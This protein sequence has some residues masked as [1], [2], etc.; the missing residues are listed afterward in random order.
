MLPLLVC[1][2][3][4]LLAPRA[5]RDEFAEQL[6]R[7]ASPRA[8]ERAAAERWLEAHLALERYPELAE[9]ALA[10]DAEVRGRLTRVLSSDA[11]H[12]GL[13]L[14]LCAEKD[15]GLAAL[16]REAL[17]TGVARFDPSLGESPVRGTQLGFFLKQLARASP[18]R[19]LR[20]DANLS[21][22]EMVEVLE[23]SGEVPLGLTFDPRLATKT[24]RREAEPL[25]GPWEQVL[26]RL[27]NSMGVGIEGHGLQPARAED[28]HEGF[29]RL[30]P[31]S[32]GTRTGVELLVDWLLTLATSAEPGA[33]ARAACNLAS[34]GFAPALEWMD[35]LVRTRDDLAARQG[36]LRAALRGR[37]ARSLS[38][39][40]LLDSLLAESA[41]GGPRSAR[42]LCALSRVPCFDAEGAA[43]APHLLQD[44]ARAAPRARWARLVLLE[45]AGCAVPELAA[46]A[47]ALLADPLTPPRLRLQALHSLAG[48]AGPAVGAPSVAGLAELV[49][50]G[51]DGEELERLG[52]SLRTLG[53]EPPY[54]EPS[55]VPAAWSA[56]ARLDLCELWLWNG[57]AERIAAHLLGWLE[58]DARAEPARGEA[59]ADALRGW[60]LRGEGARVD[61]A[62]ARAAALRPQRAALLERVRLL[63]GRVPPA[64]VGEALARVGGA[65]AGATPDLALLAALAGYPAPIPAEGAARESLLAQLGAALRENRSLDA[66]RPLL[67]ALERTAQGLYSA[68]R[69]EQADAFSK[70]VRTAIRGGGKGEVRRLLERDV[71]PGAP[72]TEERDLLRE[73]ARFE[74]PADL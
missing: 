37:V 74:V 26:A 40:P 61:A 48:Q 15:A 23:C 51:L 10:G 67:L 64:Q 25:A 3:L 71:W 7:L 4:T 49:P 5:G 47:R 45:R 56:R 1:A 34:S 39:T 41:A 12:L 55:A 46:A 65:P 73:L 28:P 18:P 9:A 54:A 22:E 32:E 52:R 70:S 19:N 29:L 16:G 21:L 58:A 63:L 13:A 62:L 6:T 38:A 20:L 17:R 57:A 24:I 35:E 8:V 30:T 72:G 50:L 36:L 2:S 33:R 68:R 27:V 59:L 11:R 60:I 42:I 66:A 44:F 31:E 69:D 43:L 14:G 53:L